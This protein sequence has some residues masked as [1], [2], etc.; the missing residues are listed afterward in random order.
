MLLQNAKGLDFLI[1]FANILQLH[2]K[3]FRN[4]TSELLCL[5]IINT[6]VQWRWPTYS[7]LQNFIA[8]NNSLLEYDAGNCRL[9][10][11][12]A[13]K[14]HVYVTTVC[15]I[16]SLNEY[17]YL[18]LYILITPVHEVLAQQI[19]IRIGCCPYFVGQLGEI[20]D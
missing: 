6:E 5:G 4:F 16:V 20:Q 9:L 17:N 1:V 13:N 11:R 3:M 10:S 19:T 12:S 14:R 2:R 18:P 8:D 15:M 7:L